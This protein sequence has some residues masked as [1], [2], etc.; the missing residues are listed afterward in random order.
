MTT[1]AQDSTSPAATLPT[2]AAAA[3]AKHGAAWTTAD[4]THEGDGETAD[5][6]PLYC[7][8]GQPRT[9]SRCREVEASAARWRALIAQ[10]R[11]ELER[12]DVAA[13]LRTLD[14]ARDEERQW[15]DDPITRLIRDAVNEAYRCQ[16]GEA[17]GTRCTWIGPRAETVV[18]EW[19]PEHLRASHAAARNSG[20][21]PHNGALRLRVER[22]TCA[23]LLT[24]SEED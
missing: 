18:V 3:Y 7:E 22:D 11:V 14:D 15:G 23:G 4:W 9:C 1:D 13:A 24:E 20:G 2:E 16:C 12:D 6:A 10:S 8:G 5:G 19:M 21:Y 17:T